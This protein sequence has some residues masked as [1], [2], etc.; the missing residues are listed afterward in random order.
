MRNVVDLFICLFFAVP[1]IIV[2]FC[3]VPRFLF[4][5]EIGQKLHIRNPKVKWTSFWDWV[6]LNYYRTKAKNKNIH[7]RTYVL[8]ILSISLSVICA[9]LVI[10]S[11]IPGL[12]RSAT[13][14]WIADKS[15]LALCLVNVFCFIQLRLKYKV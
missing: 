9:I 10:T 12:Q 2:V 11:T 14:R 5:R 7:L 1:A 6:L 3:F 4:I 13:F 8:Y 15:Y